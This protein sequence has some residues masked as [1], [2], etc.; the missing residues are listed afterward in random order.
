MPCEVKRH[1]SYL[2]RAGA[3]AFELT[4]NGASSFSEGLASVLVKGKMGYIDKTGT[5]AIA[6]QFDQARDFSEGLAA[7]E[8]IEAPG[9]K[10]D[11]GTPQQFGYVDRTGSFAIPARYPFAHS[12]SEGLAAVQLPEGGGT[13]FIDR[14]G[15]T[16]IPPIRCNVAGPFEGGLAAV[17]R[18]NGA[19]GYVNT[20]GEF[21][22][23]VQA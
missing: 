7:V 21:V 3:T 2:D 1:W 4:C 14:Q 13:A 9:G 23:P 20:R 11:S 12:F 22:W 15:R 16:V 5:T 19:V 17:H 8:V 18:D 10:R 6:P